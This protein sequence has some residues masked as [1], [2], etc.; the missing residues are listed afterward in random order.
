MREH[1]LLVA[2][3]VLACNGT[4]ARGQGGGAARSDDVL[5]VPPGFKISVFAPN[6][7]GV[8]FM[9]LGPGNAI[10]ASQPGS[11]L[12]VKL[13]DTNHDGVLAESELKDILPRLARQMQN[14][15]ENGN[16]EN[17]PQRR[18]MPQE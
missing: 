3:A 5:R 13:T 8:R 15:A 1:V 9:T 16:E 14:R 4:P 2:V 12:I 7:Q 11:G 18:P 6:L 10:Y 17:R